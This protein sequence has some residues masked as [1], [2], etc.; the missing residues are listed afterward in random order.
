MKRH[1]KII[2]WFNENF[3]LWSLEL[4]F[5][6]KGTGR[7]TDQNGNAAVVFC[8]EDGEIMFNPDH[9]DKLQPQPL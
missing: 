1:L 4:V 9:I 6:G 5:I 7:I 8:T 3:N 2:E